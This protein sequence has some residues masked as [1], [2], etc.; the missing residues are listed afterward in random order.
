MGSKGKKEKME[1]K[2]MTFTAGENDR[3]N[4]KV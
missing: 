3:G 2:Q 1:K 4:L